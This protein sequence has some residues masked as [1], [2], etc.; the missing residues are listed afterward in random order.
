MLPEPPQT[1]EEARPLLRSIL[2]PSTYASLRRSGEAVAWRQPVSAFAHELVALDFPQ[3]RLI[4]TV[5]NTKQW[6]VSWREA[7]AAGRDN[8]A[9]LHPVSTEVSCTEAPAFYDVE[10]ATYISSA[11]LT[12][13]WLAGFGRPEGPRPV[14]F[15]PSED[16]LIIGSDDPDEGAKFFEVAEKMYCEAERP[17]SPEGFTV[18]GGRLVPFDKAGP[19]PLRRLAVRARTCAAFRQ[20]EEQT[21][22]LKQA[23]EDDLVAVYVAAAQVIETGHGLASATVWGEGVT[24]DLPEVDYIVFID[25]NHEQFVVPFSVVVDVVGIAPTSA[26]FPRRY[27]VSGWPEPALMEYLRLHAVPLNAS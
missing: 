22:F 6:G 1:W 23:Y 21:E 2:R 4:V 27:R 24:Y 12:P 13:G 18:H 25:N 19:H 11:I 14:A 7:F 26:V 5:A 3:A 17:V 20:Y 16:V 15:V 10:Q 9:A 8:V